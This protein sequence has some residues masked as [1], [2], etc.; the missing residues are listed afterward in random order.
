MSELSENFAAAINGIGLCEEYADS[1]L[2]LSKPYKELEY[3]ES[4]GTQYI[5]TLLKASNSID[6]EIS[7]KCDNTSINYQR[8]YG[9]EGSVAYEMMCDNRNLTG[10][11][12][13][14][15]LVT[16][17]DPTNNYKTVKYVGSTGAVTVDSVS[18][19][20]ATPSGDTNKDLWLFRGNDRYS[21]YKLQYCK[22]WNSGNLARDFIPAKKLFTGEV[23]LYDK[24]NKTWYF[25]AGT[26]DF[27]E[28]GIKN[29]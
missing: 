2:D 9:I 14:G 25:N 20:T 7:F 23:G 17:F 4:T 13:N 18:L 29:D 8:I 11:N 27:I 6:I 21:H 5:N 19:G 16:S 10:W 24:V 12:F 22:I 28:G 1:I 15:N 26:G 3:I